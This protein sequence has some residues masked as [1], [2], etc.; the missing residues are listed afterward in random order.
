PLQD[1]DVVYQQYVNFAVPA[2]EGLGLVGPDG[3]DEIVGELLGVDVP[4]ADARIQALG[5]VPDGMQQMRLAQTGL[6][7]DE[8][9]V[10]G[11]GGSLGH[12]GGRRMGKS[13]GGA[14]HECVEGVV[15]IQA[16]IRV[17]AAGVVVHRQSGRI[18]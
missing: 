8:Q 10:V 16:R 12:G 4:H 13:V 7:V 2:L 11:L 9:R 17:H 1:L 18:S 6:P 5:V 15:R 14:D 3:V